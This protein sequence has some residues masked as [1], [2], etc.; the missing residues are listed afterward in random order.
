MSPHRPDRPRGASG[1]AI[2]LVCA[3]E[4]ERLEAIEKTIRLSI[5]RKIVPGYE[6]DGRVA[7]TMM[8]RPRAV[9]TVVAA[10]AAASTGELTIAFCR[11]RRRVDS[12]ALA[13]TRRRSRDPPSP[14]PAGLLIIVG[15]T[16]P[17]G[18]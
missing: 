4:H 2:S 17:S 8:S 12:V 7:P 16:L 13:A 3:E 5:P 14:R 10:G 6:P 15:A 1:E 18:S 11:L 9:A